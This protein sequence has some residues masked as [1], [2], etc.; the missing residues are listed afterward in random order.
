MLKNKQ[1]NK[2][3]SPKTKFDFIEKK[4]SNKTNRIIIKTLETK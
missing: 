3:F 2:N 1:T 4:N